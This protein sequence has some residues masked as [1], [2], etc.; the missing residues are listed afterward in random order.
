MPTTTYVVTVEFSVDETDRDEHLR[1]EDA[2]EGEITSWLESLDAEVHAVQ[3]Q[4][5]KIPR[6]R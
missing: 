6:A 5:E 3:V 1:D 2:V 4:R